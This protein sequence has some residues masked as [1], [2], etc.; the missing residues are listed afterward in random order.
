MSALAQSDET[1]A[2]KMGKVDKIQKEFEILKA[3]DLE[4]DEERTP[5]SMHDRLVKV[6]GEYTML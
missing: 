4:D 1:F 3:G 5:Q 2:K 6:E